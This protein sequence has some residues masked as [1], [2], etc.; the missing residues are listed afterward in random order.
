LHRFGDGFRIAV[1]VFVALEEAFTYLAGMS[2]A[3][4]PKALSRRL[5]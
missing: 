1:V 5:K 4:W 3:S 2:L